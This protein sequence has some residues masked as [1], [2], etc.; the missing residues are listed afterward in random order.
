VT[1]AEYCP[2]NRRAYDAGTCDDCCA[3][4]DITA[5][6]GT[7]LIIR[8]LAILA[9]TTTSAVVVAACTGSSA[10]ADPPKPPG[11]R[12]IHLPDNYPDLAT[13]CDPGTG[14]RIYVGSYHY[15][16]AAVR[17]PSCDR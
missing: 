13:F 2:D 3:R 6:P 10:P 7:R 5:K 16:P 9:A 17:D 15:A 4:P 8:G 14:N 12:I 11:W 1:S